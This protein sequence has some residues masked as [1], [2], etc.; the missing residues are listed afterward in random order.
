MLVEFLEICGTVVK[1]IKNIFYKGGKI[2]PLLNIS[3]LSSCV[4]V[5]TS[6]QILT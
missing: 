4:S 5:W 6:C 3:K 1:E 2:N